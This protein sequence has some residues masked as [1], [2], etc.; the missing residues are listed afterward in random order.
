MT[1]NIDLK[2]HLALIKTQDG[3]KRWNSIFSLANHATNELFAI[4]IEYSS[5]SLSIDRILSADVLGRLGDCDL[6]TSKGRP[7]GEASLAALLGMLSVE[8]DTKVTLSI[9]TALQHH[10]HHKI[11][12]SVV[13]F[14]NSCSADIRRA[15]A[16]AITGYVDPLAIDTLLELSKDA[17]VQTRNWSVFAISQQI[18]TSST[19]IIECLRNACNDENDEVRAEGLY[20]LAIRN[21]SQFARLALSVLEQDWVHKLAIQAIIK[22]PVSIVKERLTELLACSDDDA[23]SNLLLQAISKCDMDN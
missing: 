18:E 7:L 13:P 15:V 14:K 6:A 4:T 23:M 22:R 2:N 21:D 8:K 3:E 16:L 9:I 11:I 1:K 19:E 10:H 17:D 5:S 12:G 20:G